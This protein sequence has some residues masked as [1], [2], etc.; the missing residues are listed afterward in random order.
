MAG[1]FFPIVE[2]AHAKWEAAPPRTA[3]S[4]NFDFVAQLF[5]M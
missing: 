2:C 5:D 4:V 3:Q 1:A